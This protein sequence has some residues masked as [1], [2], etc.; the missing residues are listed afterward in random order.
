[1]TRNIIMLGTGSALPVSNYHACYIVRTNSFTLLSDAGG[2]NGILYNLN[3]AGIAPT[4]ITHLI[5]SH[6]HTDHIFGAVW[7]IRVLINS[8]FNG[9]KVNKLR[10]Y[11]NQ[12]TANALIE[13]CRLTF[14][15]SYFS[16]IDTVVDL[17]IITPPETDK[18]EDCKIRFF[19]VGS[20]NVSQMGFRLSFADGTTFVSLGDEALTDR[21]LYEA[22]GADYLICG[23]F[24]R[25]ADRDTF[26]PYEKHHFTV[27]DV[28]INAAKAK[29]K[30]LILYHSEDK[31]ADKTNKYHAEAAEF[32]N[33]NAIIPND[34]DIISF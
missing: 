8:Y 18:I 9:S 21:N 25:Y 32:Y 10:V 16:E 5:L 26:K 31:T 14:L 24:C 15:E 19:D 11:A 17:H 22:S 27:K 1:M 2:G 34:L 28:A 4:E 12:Q 7:L 29:V 30:N 13:I 6:A 33:G 20:E 23:A 3:A